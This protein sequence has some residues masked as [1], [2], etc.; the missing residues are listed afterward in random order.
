MMF[1]NPHLNGAATQGDLSLQL[2]LTNAQQDSIIS[3]LYDPAD[4]IR[5]NRLRVLPL[6]PGWQPQRGGAITTQAEYPGPRAGDMMQ[7]VLRARQKNPALE[8]GIAPSVFD[9][10][11]NTASPSEIAAYIKS[12]VDFAVSK[13]IVPQ[14][15]GIQNEPS[16]TPPRFSPQ[17]V[18]DI[19]VSLRQKLDAS[20]STVGIS[21]PDDFTDITAEAHLKALFADDAGR[22]S[23]RWLSVHLYDDTW[24][25]RTQAFSAQYSLP[26]W[27]TE[28]D[29]RLADKEVG[30][31]SKYIN[32]LI[33]NY[34][35]SAVDMLYGFL[36]SQGKGNPSA[37][38]IT[39]NANST[40]YLGYT[41]NPSYFEVGQYSRFIGRGSVRIAA[42]SSNT[43]IK[44]S[45]FDTGGKNIL[46]MIN[47]SR[48]AANVSIPRGVYRVVRTQL[49]G[50]D[51]LTDKGL[52][53]RSLTLPERS[54]TTLIEQ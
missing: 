3:K 23:V 5:L 50:S 48:S 51:R 17:M 12:G 26:W 32:D 42:S 39:L 33:V 10:W 41:L 40:S 1:D 22:K 36:S 8:I 30:W 13:G 28:Y 52:F 16:L 29:D 45:A 44:I 25:A 31:A 47:T 35:C 20:G 15:V 38:Y 54:I 14:W 6:Q 46:V 4:G 24:P 34:N 21:A 18:H 19:A 11:V 7:F 49:S 43:A 37:T 9:S 53:K 2:K 27:M